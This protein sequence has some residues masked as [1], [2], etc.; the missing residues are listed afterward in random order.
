MSSFNPHLFVHNIHSDD[1][2]GKKYFS[3]SSYF[4]KSDSPAQSVSH[5]P[6]TNILFFIIPPEC[7]VEKSQLTGD[8]KFA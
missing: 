6:E 7:C 4:P 1:R 5:M 3:I 8:T 2:D